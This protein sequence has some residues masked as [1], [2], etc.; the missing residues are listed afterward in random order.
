MRV[1]APLP[2]ADVLDL[3]DGR[4]VE[5]L[6]VL[7]RGA[8]ATVHRAVLR[9]PSGIRKAVA[10]KMFGRLATEDER[11]VLEHL[12][13]TARRVAS[14]QHPN[15]VELIDVGRWESQPF[16]VSELV[17]GKTLSQLLERHG[18]R[19]PRLP[20]DLALFLGTE[21]AEAL[22]GARVARDHRGREVGLLHL[23]LG[24]RKILLSWRGEVKVTDFETAVA[25]GASSGVRSLRAVLHRT[26]TMAP[27]V[28]R[29]EPGDSRSDV[30]SLGIVLRE[31]LVGPRFA[32]TTTNV[33]AARLA[34][35]G[36]IE[37][38]SFQPN[39]P[40]DLALILRRALDP[41]PRERYPNASV[42]VT[43]LRRVALTM[44]VGDGR[45]LLRRALDREWG[46]WRE[47]DPAPVFPGDPSSSDGSP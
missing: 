24:P 27:E 3:G 40:G 7:G 35:E 10:L 37:P 11:G 9:A 28:A 6:G 32:R 34:R 17:E 26:A 43:D 47:G 44:G 31:L 38:L 30:F 16:F 5:I 4:R 1:L 39:L 19:A 8:S 33:E 23:A 20:L 45:E 29:G 18:A 13:R 25:T 41:D 14:V 36:F 46:E 21:V 12:A 42:L 2:P 15:V 22:A